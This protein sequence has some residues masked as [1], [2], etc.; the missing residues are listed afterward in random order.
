MVS[1]SDFQGCL[2]MEPSADPSIHLSFCP[3]L[4][5]L[6]VARFH[7]YTHGGLTQ[8]LQGKGSMYVWKKISVALGDKTTSWPDL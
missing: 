4:P 1:Q 6:L 7:G 8:G 2:P 3:S 5:H